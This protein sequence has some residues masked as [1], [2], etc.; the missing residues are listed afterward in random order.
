MKLPSAAGAQDELRLI[1]RGDQF[2]ALEDALAEA[3]NRPPGRL[4]LVS[5]EAGIG[6]TALLTHFCAGLGP[7]VRV[8]WAACDPLFTPRPLGPLLDVSR[9]TGG[10]LEEK[11]E[12]GAQPHDVTAALLEELS[13]P[14]PTIGSGPGWSQSGWKTNGSVCGPPR[15]PW[16]PT[17]SSK[18]AVSSV[19][20]L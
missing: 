8:L 17:N 11:V 15:P 19:S 5:G 3:G 10:D 20:G 16:L 7:R 18:A 2:A 14:A 12:A 13:A 6:K 9:V 4:V 1:E